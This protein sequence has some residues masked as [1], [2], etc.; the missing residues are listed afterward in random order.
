MAAKKRPDNRPARKRYRL[1]GRR[2]KNKER[3][4]AKQA[5]KEAKKREKLMK[6][7]EKMAKEAETTEKKEQYKMKCVK[8]NGKIVRVSDRTA[9]EM[10]DKGWDYCPKHEYKERKRKKQHLIVAGDRL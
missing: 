2:E 1:E 9:R 6:R 8:K 3:R 5:R 7:A 4:I 10:A